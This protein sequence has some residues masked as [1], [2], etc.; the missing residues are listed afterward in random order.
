M[1]PRAVAPAIA[2]LLFGS[3]IVAMATVANPSYTLSDLGPGT[4]NAI[5]GAGSVVGA[6]PDGGGTPRAYLWT[7]ASQTQTD[8]GI[9]NSSANG[10]NDAGVVVGAL[11]SS[12]V[13]HGFRWANGSTTD[14]G[15]LSGFTGSS[16]ADVNTSGQVV[17]TCTG[18]SGSA[19]RPFLWAGGPMSDLGTLGGSQ[20]SAAAIN[21][22][23]T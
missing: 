5:N 6:K 14:L 18:G 2:V 8:L 1:T 4:A 3:F 19:T 12:G 22:G 20:S 9:A 21:D 13:T 23:G 15:T 11:T 7:N 16:A 17:G 10:V